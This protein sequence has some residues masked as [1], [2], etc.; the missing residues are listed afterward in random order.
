MRI[1][2]GAN[3]YLKHAQNRIEPVVWDSQSAMNGHIMIM[4]GSGA[5][6]THLARQLLNDMAKANAGLRAHVFDVH[7]DIDR[8]DSLSTVKFSE[9][10]PYGY[11]PLA[12]TDCRD[13]GGVR[14]RIQSFTGALNRT[15]R[16][17]GS[18][19]LAAGG[20]HTP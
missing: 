12:I 3:A 17:L 8:L 6:K 20:R 9:Q 4:G 2:I 7:G 5:G 16:K 11:N 15:S 10:T 19:Q 1:T 13:S 14:R 18:R